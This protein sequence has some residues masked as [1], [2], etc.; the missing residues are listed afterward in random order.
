MKPGNKWTAAILMVVMTVSLWLPS[1]PAQA[2]VVKKSNE[3]IVFEYLT[4]T[5]KLPSSAACG[6]MA[7]IERESEFNPKTSGD[8]GSSYGIVQWHGSLKSELISYCRSKNLDYKTLEAQLNFMGYELQHGDYTNV[9]RYLKNV[10]DDAY[11]AYKAGFYFCYYY[12]RP[13]GYMKASVSRGDLARQK[14]WPKYG[15]KGVSDVP[16]EPPVLSGASVPGYMEQGARL[17][18]TG[19]VTSN[20]ELT[21][22]TAGFYYVNEN[23]ASVAWKDPEGT[24]FSLKDLAG[25]IHAEKLEPGSYLF[26]ITASNAGGT[27]V[28]VSQTVNVLYR[29]TTRQDANVQFQMVDD[30]RLVLTAAKDGNGLVLSDNPGDNASH[31]QAVGLSSGYY[32]LRSL[33]L[34]KYLTADRDGNLGFSAWSGS[35]YQQWQFLA[36]AG[37]MM[38]VVPRSAQSKLVSVQEALEEGAKVRLGDGALNELQLFRIE[39]VNDPSPIEKPLLQVD[40]VSLELPKTEYSKILGNKAFSLKAVSDGT[41]MYE[42]SVP[43]VASVDANGKVTIHATGLTEIRVTASGQGK[44]SQSAVVVVKVRPKKMT[45]TKASSAKKQKITIRWNK[46]AMADGYEVQYSVSSKFSKKKTGTVSSKD[47]NSKKCTLSKLTSKKV[48]YLRIRAFKNISD[49]KLYGAWSKAV[50]VTVK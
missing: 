9:G 27:E 3:Q 22:V 17:D 28:L 30:R 15:H 24:V 19:T 25:D 11:G 41:L 13:S 46:D 31:F 7:N 49:G 6:V 5:L 48:Y 29:M 45:I 20:V 37:T 16:P 44:Q 23:E 26:E 12:E 40:T 36:S 14:Y 10:S 33:A 4:G 32:S 2:A 42:S 34:N 47:N 39:K 21:R 50:K 8:G 43:S 38:V 35:S 1:V 18:L